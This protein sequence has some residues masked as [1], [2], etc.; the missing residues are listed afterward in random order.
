ME[1]YLLI[2]LGSSVDEFFQADH[3]PMEGSYTDALEKGRRAGGPPLNMGCVCASKGANV[4]GLDYLS[5]T[6]DSS[7][8]LIETLQSYG[9]D[10]SHVIKG[11]AVNGKVLIVNTAE[12]RTMFVI[13]PQ[14]PYYAIGQKIKDLINNATYIYTMM[15]II[16]RSFED[17]DI[18][19][20]AKRNGTRF[21]FDGCGEYKEKWE[22]DILY[23]L[24]DGLFI[25]KEDY[26]HLKQASCKDPKEILFENGC[27]FI[28]I[29]D[30]ENGA[31]CYTKEK[32]Y[33]AQACK[34][35]VID[36]T[37]AGDS[38][39]G[40]F[41]YGLLKE[42]P[43]E[44]CLFLASVAGAYATTALGG[45]AACVKEDVLIEFAEKQHYG[46]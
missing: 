42:Y 9:V 30:G 45:Q 16:H 8:F 25:N 34:C 41:V 17:L 2:L 37:G 21:I 13:Q 26:A 10:T 24:A 22:A 46:G 35:E 27:S 4:K 12:K 39:A 14:R 33:I 18:L 23:Q 15:Y 20:Q 5:D 1:P 36:S 29:T 31:V 38:F 3:W 28:C 11:D 7:D 32:D 43:Y 40:T 19:L 44:R 6:D